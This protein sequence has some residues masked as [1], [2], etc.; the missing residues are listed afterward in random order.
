M[1]E[2]RPFIGIYPD[3]MYR[4]STYPHA[5]WAGDTLYVSGQVATDADGAIV[6][7]GDSAA[8]AAQV[9]ANV[10]TVLAAA[11]VG[12]EHVVK[13]MTY[14]T[15]AA[16]RAP[17]TAARLRFFGDHRPP[18]TGLVIAALGSPDVLFEVEV[19]AYR[20]QP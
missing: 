15:P 2:Q 19:I 8:Q 16:D 18:H 1:H 11:G 9:W 4:P 12:P 17:I 6:G 7:V 5:M 20:S 10:G 13:V 3:G 14:L